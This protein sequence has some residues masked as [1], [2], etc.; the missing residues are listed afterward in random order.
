MVGSK[1]LRMEIQ[2]GSGMYFG[3]IR[4]KKVKGVSRNQRAYR[5]GIFSI[6][7]TSR[8]TISRDFFVD[9]MKEDEV[10][11]GEKLSPMGLTVNIKRRS[12]SLNA[13]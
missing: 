5:W 7:G 6:I 12:R 8:K 1:N 11:I 13:N 9:G 3:R 4:R 10:V 2:I